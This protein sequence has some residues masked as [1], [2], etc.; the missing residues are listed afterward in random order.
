VSY[1]SFLVAFEVITLMHCLDEDTHMTLYTTLSQ[2][3]GPPLHE[4]ATAGWVG[5][6]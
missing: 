6:F 1:R 4:V 3:L 2:N 5:C